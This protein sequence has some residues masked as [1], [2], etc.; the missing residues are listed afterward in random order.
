MGSRFQTRLWSLTTDNP[1]GAVCVARIL[2]RIPCTNT[3]P[4][5]YF[6]S[7]LGLMSLYRGHHYYAMK[8]CL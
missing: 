3:H 7:L 1:G 4:A 2:V 5:F 6:S 8:L